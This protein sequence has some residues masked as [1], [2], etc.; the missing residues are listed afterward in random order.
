MKKSGSISTMIVSLVLVTIGATGC[1]TKGF[2]RKQVTPVN[3]RVSDL[4]Q[5]TNEQIQALATKEQSDVSRLDERISSTDSR[6]AEVNTVAQR[7]STTAD[8]ANQLG[9]ANRM[10]IQT[11]SQQIGSLG[12]YVQNAWNYQLVEKGDVMF[13]FD[14]SRLDQGSKTALDAIARKAKSVPRTVIDLQGFA[15]KTGGSDYNLAL[16]QKRA[17]AVARYLMTQHN[18]PLRSIS[19]MGLGEEDPPANITADFGAPPANASPQ[20]LRQFSRRVY[21]RILAPATATTGE[22]ARSE[23]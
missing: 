2:V 21:I 10:E 20:E 22:A 13:A 4:E 18:V 19:I 3:Q 15:D 1:A 23:R 12:Q 9:Q 5:K 14:K 17:D 8:Q 6:L 11:T 16:S 7:A